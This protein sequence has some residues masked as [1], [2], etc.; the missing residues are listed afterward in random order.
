[1]LGASFLGVVNLALLSV[2]VGKQL[3][4]NGWLALIV[5]VPAGLLSVVAVGTFMDMIGEAQ[6]NN[7]EIYYNRSPRQQQAYRQI[8][9]IHK[10]LKDM[11]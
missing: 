8:D 2:S 6:R 1:M 5:I 4:F 3:G 7:E 10:M 9:E 11:K